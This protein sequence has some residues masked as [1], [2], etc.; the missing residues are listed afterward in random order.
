M[1]KVTPVG[2]HCTE[3]EQEGQ[4]PEEICL[5]SEDCDTPRGGCLMLAGSS[6]NMLYSAHNY[7]TLANVHSNPIPTDQFIREEAEAQRG[8]V[9]C[10]IAHRQP[11][12]RRRRTF[13]LQVPK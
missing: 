13:Y 10:P 1:Q 6:Q 7:I 4:G 8:R 12:D 5:A 2:V 11:R 9:N 3:E